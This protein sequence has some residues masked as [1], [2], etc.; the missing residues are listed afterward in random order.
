[1]EPK[2]QV[3]IQLGHMCNNRC[4]FCV[5]GQ[6]TALGRARPLSVE[7]IL[8][9]LEEAY[10]TG[11]R[12]VTLLGGE[13]T[14]QPGFMT[15]VER[16]VALGFEEIV[17]F[18]NGVKTAREGFID[19]V[20]RTGGR[21]TWRISIQGAT[22]ESHERTTR[23]PGSFDRILRSMEHLRRLGQRVTVNMCVVGSN[24]ESVE[25]FPELVAEYGVS[26]L[27]LDMIR[28][29]DAGE[30]TEGEFREM[31]ARYTDM[32]PA[33]SKLAEGVPKEFDLNIGNLP[34]CVAPHLAA[35]IH[36]DGEETLTVAVD[37][38]N[39][40]SRPWNKYFVKRRDKSKPLSCR[41]CVFNSRCNG[42]FEK[43]REFHGESEFV[44]L[45]AEQLARLDPEH[46][47]LA[48]H[49]APRLAVASWPAPP[50]PFD[51]VGV[52]ELGERTLHLALSG[53]DPLVLALR[54]PGGGVAGFEGFALDVVRLPVSRDAARAGI[55]F[56]REQL[57]ALG[58]RVVHPLGPDAIAG[59]VSPALMSRLSRLRRA[60]P[61]GELEWRDLG[62]LE[63]GVRAEVRLVARD[64]QGATVWLQDRGG[65]VTAG[66]VLPDGMPG[67][68]IVRGIREILTALSPKGRAAPQPAEQKLG[69]VWGG[70]ELER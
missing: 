67:E 58:H 45:S 9:R 28:P 29:L 34:Y 21:F 59:D 51:G 39:A 22:K 48:V 38:E 62:V 25:H 27:H 24:Y 10:R 11:H 63:E 36:H 18:T 60:A 6:Q 4:V 5:S 14:L 55:G 35:R 2:R 42:I 15:V 65:K 31:M 66:Y 43:Y 49:L 50:A 69:V 52:T 44:P 13:P 61:F 41:S 12:K 33:L 32:V 1:M 30:R 68:A 47:L 53:K 7:P 23:R 26:Q 57:A 64:G 37:G 17:V 70:G 56:V 19:D 20:V 46:R 54:P 40:L 3:E 16:A 8:E